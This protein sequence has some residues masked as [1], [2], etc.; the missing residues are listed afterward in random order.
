MNLFKV[1]FVEPVDRDSRERFA[2][3]IRQRLS[4]A[5]IPNELEISL[6]D[7]TQ[8]GLASEILLMAD[9]LKMAANFFDL[10]P[11]DFKSEFDFA[12]SDHE[13]NC[14]K[15]D[16]IQNIIDLKFTKR[17]QALV[18]TSE[19]DERIQ[20][21]VLAEFKSGQAVVVSADGATLKTNFDGIVARRLL[22]NERDSTGHSVKVCTEVELI[23]I[24]QVTFL[25]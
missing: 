19:F 14:H 6:S 23:P 8:S 21:L 24:E 16:L 7:R 12:Q 11:E 5:I 20:V 4:R 17:E 3:S 2:Q 10:K 13:D 9:H 1:K 18:Q 25:N 22:M 15:F